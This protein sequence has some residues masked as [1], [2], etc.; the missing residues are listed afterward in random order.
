MAKK[1]RPK[2]KS[3]MKQILNEISNDLE[4]AGHGIRR[5]PNGPAKVGLLERLLASYDTLISML[6][7]KVEQH[8]SKIASDHPQRI[9]VN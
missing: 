4:Q 6:K 9:Q 2:K 7:E 8:Q 1:K 5:L 3:E